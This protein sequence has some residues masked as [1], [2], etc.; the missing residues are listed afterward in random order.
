MKK[1]NKENIEIKQ[2]IKHLAG[3]IS[4]P[5]N[6]DYKEFVYEY[7]WEKHTQLDNQSNNS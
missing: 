4:L 3:F 2:E 6:F 1:L 5:K 7:L